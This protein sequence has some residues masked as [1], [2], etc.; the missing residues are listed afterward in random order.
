[1]GKSI[2]P[3]PGGKAVL[4]PWIVSHLPNHH[5]YV[6]VFGGSASVLLSKAESPVEVYNDRDGDLVHFFETFRD[7]TDELV[8][9]LQDTPYAR[10]IHRKW[11]GEFYA[12][13]RPDDDVERAA[14]F[15]YIRYTQ[16][17]AKYNGL[18]GF[19]SA[20]QRSA[21]RQLNSAIARLQEFADRFRDVVVENEDYA[22]IFDRFDG[23]ETVFYCDPPYVQE[24]DAL[25]THGEFDHTRFVDEL[26]SLDGKWVVSYTDI[27][28]GL[29][30]YHTE[31]RQ[32][33]YSSQ[34]GSD[35][36]HK[37]ATE[38]LVMSFDPVDEPRATGPNASLA[39]F[40]E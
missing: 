7:H 15:F 23:D 21:A 20:K 1:M 5:C 26:L 18:S 19:K 28:E 40:A 24:G 25:Y 16:F 14:R 12:G 29:G 33:S 17:A 31:E 30:D 37:E 3:Y 22:Y 2:F 11:A 39:G 32:V 13:Y 36:S 8:A 27:P 9:Y 4:S 38:R 6:E 35:G 10:D 34:N